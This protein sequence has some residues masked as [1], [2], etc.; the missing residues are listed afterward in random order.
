MALDIVSSWGGTIEIAQARTVGDFDSAFASLAQRRINALT[1]QSDTLFRFGYERLVALAARY[2]IPMNLHAA[3]TNFGGLMSYTA[4]AT[5]SYRQAGRY[6][7]GI[8]KGEKPAD[9]P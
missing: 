7:G 9:I 5:D 6:A 2:A 3:L 8:L 4:N 1:T